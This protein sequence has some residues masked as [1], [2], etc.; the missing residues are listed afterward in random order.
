[1]GKNAKIFLKAIFDCIRLL[2]E[3]KKKK[4]TFLKSNQS[5]TKAETRFK[6]KW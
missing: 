5:K 4:K 1:M 6:K 3:F 2:K